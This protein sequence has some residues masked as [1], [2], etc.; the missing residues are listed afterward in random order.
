MSNHNLRRK[1]PEVFLAFT[2]MTMGSAALAAC[3]PNN[4][5]ATAGGN[6]ES[7]QP[8]TNNPTT[9]ASTS[10]P[11][12][13]TSAAEANQT[14]TVGEKIPVVGDTKEVEGVTYVWTEAQGLGFYMPT[15]FVVDGS[16]TASPN[17]DAWTNGQG[18][19]FRVT[20]IE[21]DRVPKPDDD[22][23]FNV[24]TISITGAKAS[25]LSVITPGTDKKGA[26]S[27]NYPEYDIYILRPGDDK[28]TR[29][30]ISG[31]GEAQTDAVMAYGKNLEVQV[32]N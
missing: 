18:V 27:T 31:N 7:S 23:V 4:A 26:F 2:L 16:V 9:D 10:T 25:V 22:P 20:H 13:T 21:S 28:Y 14:T 32:V 11:D 12:S 17:Y 3:T 6:T 30:D 15:D 1:L 19:D 5:N 8:T 29:I 24:S